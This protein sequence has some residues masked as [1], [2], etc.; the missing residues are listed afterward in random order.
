[1]NVYLHSEFYATFNKNYRNEHAKVCLETGPDRARLFV[2]VFGSGCSSSFFLE[3]VLELVSI[4]PD[5][6]P[7]KKV[8]IGWM[9]SK[10]FISLG[11]EAFIGCV[12]CIKEYST[13][14]I[15]P[16]SVNDKQIPTIKF[17]LGFK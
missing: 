15:I 9:S 3:I 2:L 12:T 8:A 7:V 4:I 13:A 17:K 11:A 5:R 14:N 10:N 6:V 16:V 1:M